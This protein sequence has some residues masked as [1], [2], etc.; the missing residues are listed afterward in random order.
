MRQ[1]IDHKKRVLEKYLPTEHLDYVL[2]LL[3]SYPVKFRV[4]KPR[5]TK[6][7]DFRYN[8]NGLHQISV[9]GDLNQYAFLITLVHEFAHLVSYQEH[10]VRIRPH[11]PEW[12]SCYAKLLRPVID[13]ETLPDDVQHALINSLINI[14]ASSCSD[15]RLYKVLMKYDP[16]DDE[17][18]LLEEVSMNSLF[19]FNGRQFSKGELRRT[20]YLCMENNTQKI[21]LV[22][23]LAKV[24]VIKHGE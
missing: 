22:S 3:A 21:Y 8:R 24:K 20:R 4:S 19:E 6:L 17:L 23:S 2:D 5:K 16:L 1:T 12:Q 14:K 13:S 15:K 18:S 9:N 10:G 11:G 7:G